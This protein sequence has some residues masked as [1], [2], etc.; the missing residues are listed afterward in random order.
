[1]RF[2]KSLVHSGTKPMPRPVETSDTNEK[3][4]SQLGNVAGQTMGI[5]HLGEIV[6][7]E[8]FWIFSHFSAPV[9]ISL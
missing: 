6:L 7:A 9:S 8:R 3:V 1:M 5:E 4:S 2:A